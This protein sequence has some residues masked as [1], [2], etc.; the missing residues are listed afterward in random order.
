[1]DTD[2]YEEGKL[3]DVVRKVIFKRIKFCKG[4]GAVSSKYSKKVQQAEK[5]RNLEC[6]MNVKT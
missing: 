5:K 2:K 3:K 4:E 6:H 1:M